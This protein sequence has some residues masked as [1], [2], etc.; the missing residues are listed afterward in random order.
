MVGF[1]IPGGVPPHPKATQTLGRIQKLDPLYRPIITPIYNPY[2][3]SHMV[4]GDLI[5][6][7][8]WGSG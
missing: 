2:I 5:F 3:I 7:S 8:L 1:G 4:L 6:G